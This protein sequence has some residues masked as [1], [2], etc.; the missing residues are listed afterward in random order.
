[1]RFQE[2]TRTSTESRL[3]I[4]PTMTQRQLTKSK[5]WYTALHSGPRHQIASTATT[6]EAR[7][8]TPRAQGF[9]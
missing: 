8:S 4:A 7:T 9:S 2:T 5:A 6:S 3:R 1:V